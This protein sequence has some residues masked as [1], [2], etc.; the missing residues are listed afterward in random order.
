MNANAEVV[1]KFSDQLW[2][3]NNLY[4]IQD[5]SGKEVLFN[6]NTAQEQLYHE[7]WYRNVI[8]K[9]RQR[10]FTT[11]LDLFALDTCIFNINYKAGI[12]AHN[13]N[14]AQ[15]IFR[16]KVKYPYER[17]PDQ[18]KHAVHPVN[19]S[20]NEYIFSNESEINVSTSYR[21]GT[22]QFLH[23]SEFGKIAAKD[24]IKAEE[25]ISGALEAVP[26]DGMATFEST[27]EGN[28]GDFFDM[29]EQAQKNH[30]SNTKLTPLDFKFIFEPWHN[31]P[32]YTLGDDA[33]VIIP[34]DSKKYFKALSREHGIELSKGQRKWY[35]AKARTLGKKMKREYPSHWKEA[36]EVAI[37]GAYFAEEM[38]K[39]RKDGRICRV[40]IIDNVD[41]E[42]FWDLG[43]NDSTAIW[44][45]QRVGR[46]FRFIYYYENSNHSLR[47][48]AKKLKEL[49]KE[50]EWEY[51]DHYLPHDVEV[52]DLSSDDDKSRKSILEENGVKPIVVVPKTPEK[53]V[54]IEQG[55]E[56]L[57]YCVFDIERCDK[58]IKALDNFRRKWDDNHGVFMNEPLRNWAKHGADAFLQCAQ[59]YEEEEDDWF[60]DPN[61]FKN[62][63]VSIV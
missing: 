52:T 15:K 20:R 48:Y 9:A 1:D 39:I 41:V 24:P 10:G 4:Y 50:Y 32:E 60:N 57:P 56:L 5:K 44:F 35:V 12:I 61:F 30:V 18:I 42:T 37:E 53:L 11:F 55:R 19:D 54:A 59:G 43:R 7:L 25:I 23:V 14:D 47:Y 40:P 29:V 21:S 3:L 28:G 27:A 6:M 46:E 31:N 38:E 36:F 2:R 63:E 26:I 33:E 62:V 49:K 17:L 16:S 8:L 22:L 34:A 58:G 51:G 13:L 45:M